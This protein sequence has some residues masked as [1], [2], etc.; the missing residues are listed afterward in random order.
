VL[1]LLETDGKTQQG[2][3]CADRT[4]GQEALTLKG[5]TGPVWCVAFTGDGKS[6]ISGH[7]NGTVVVTPISPK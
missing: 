5:H 7:D 2:S 4:T 6:L 3:T 1:Q